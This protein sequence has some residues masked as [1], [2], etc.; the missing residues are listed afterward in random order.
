VDDAWD[1]EIRI[2]GLL[3]E[4]DHSRAEVD[5]RV[6]L[7]PGAP[8][9]RGWGHWAA[10]LFL[11][12]LAGGAAYAAPGSPLPGMLEGL[13]RERSRARPQTTT[14]APEGRAASPGAGVAVEPGEHLTIRFLVD[15]EA[16]ATV[17]LTDGQEAEVRAV[18]G[19]ASFSSGDDQLT[20]QGTGRVRFEILVPRSAPSLD[21][22][23]G[24]TPVLRK[25]AAEVISD[26]P[27]EPS[28][29]Y[30]LRLTPLP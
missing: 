25:R 18:E 15:R 11:L 20:V 3:R 27:R 21:V 1:E 5:P 24:D 26:A 14:Q 23:A 12:V 9:R 22:L 4:L 17:S 8:A 10:G 16:I 19:T 30:R 2:F 29:G 13:V 6:L 28:G 7:S